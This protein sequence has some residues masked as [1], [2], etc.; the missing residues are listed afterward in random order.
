M[1]LQRG[2][3]V[4]TLAVECCLVNRRLG[5]VV[6]RG[7]SNRVGI[8]GN[9]ILQNYWL[10][11]SSHQ[12]YYSNLKVLLDREGQC[13]F[14]LVLFQIDDILFREQLCWVGKRIKVYIMFWKRASEREWVHCEERD[15]WQQSQQA[16]REDSTCAIFACLLLQR[17][18]GIQCLCYAQPMP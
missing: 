8:Y 3:V 12:V 1:S 17:C 10:T 4:S 7:E 6:A 2:N 11:I 15:R 9:T 18:L 14:S 16:I 13:L 5:R